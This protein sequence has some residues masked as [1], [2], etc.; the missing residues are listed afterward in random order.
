MGLYLLRPAPRPVATDL[1]YRSVSR[2]SSR[3]RLAKL[4][5]TRQHDACGNT[6]PS[7]GTDAAFTQ[8]LLADLLGRGLRQRGDEFD[9]A[10]HHER[11]QLLI[12]PGDQRSRFDALTFTQH[13][14]GD[15]KSTRLNSSH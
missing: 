8:I 14:E 7:G 10:R 1:P 6:V 9:V 2:R 11:G 4:E 15:R 3:G 12:A 13:D 5:F